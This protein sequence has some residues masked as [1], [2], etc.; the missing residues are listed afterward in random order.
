MSEP[1][2]FTTFE[3]YGTDHLALAAWCVLV[4]LS[5]W[6]VGQAPADAGALAAE[7]GKAADSAVEADTVMQPGWTD[8]K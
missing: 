4:E 8:E 7:L 1:A 5:K 3:N 6:A 2:T